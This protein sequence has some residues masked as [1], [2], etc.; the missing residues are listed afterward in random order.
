[1][2]W[3]GPQGRHSALGPRC[4]SL[5][6][7]RPPG[8]SPEEG[9][10][11]EGTVLGRP[12]D[13]I[14][15]ACP[16]CP[17]VVAVDLP[18]GR[19]ARPRGALVIL[20]TSFS[21]SLQPVPWMP[22]KG[23]ALPSMVEKGRHLGAWPVT[24]GSGCG[25]RGPCLCSPLCVAGWALVH[26]EGERLLRVCVCVCV[27]VC[28]R[29]RETDRQT[30]REVFRLLSLPGAHPCGA[31]LQAS[32][33]LQHLGGEGFSVSPPHREIQTPSLLNVTEE[34]NTCRGGKGVPIYSLLGAPVTEPGRVRL[35]G[36]A[37][38]SSNTRPRTPVEPNPVVK[39]GSFSRRGRI[40][41]RSEQQACTQ[42]L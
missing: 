5:G 22:L 33:P 2:T 24:S 1:M 14:T 16:V 30:E 18:A 37:P 19:Q 25:L 32:P 36:G 9:L 28:V 17:W 10:G 39:N 26:P 29:E 7:R 31:N 38:E 27:C 8:G 40:Q 3:L 23:W 41:V 42:S 34:E 4:P 6:H 35:A 21:G 15:D 13:L 20:E 11:G 12:Q